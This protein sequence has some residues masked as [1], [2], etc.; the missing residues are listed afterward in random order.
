MPSDPSVKIKI[1]SKQVEFF[2]KYF[3][4]TL[5]QSPYQRQKAKTIV[6]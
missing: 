3:L 6:N 4:F 2:G 5:G 1:I